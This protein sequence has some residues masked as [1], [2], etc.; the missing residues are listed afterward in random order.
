MN[1]VREA[2]FRFSQLLS[3]RH[4]QLVIWMIDVA[5][6]PAAFL[7]ACMFT[8][9]EI[10]PKTQLVRL[11]VMFPTLAL[12]GGFAS[13]AFGLPWI[14]LKTYESFGF[15]AIAPYA[16]TVGAV[17]LFMSMAPGLYFPVVGTLAFTLVLFLASMALRLGTLKLYFWSLRLRKPQIRV[18][19]YGAGTTGLQLASALKSHDTIQV[20]A[21]ID[22]DPGL[23]RERLAGLRI[24]PSHQ[25]DEIVR[26]HD[27]SRVI[28]A[29]PSLPA[30]QLAR[31]GRQLQALGLEVQTVP[32]F[33]QLLG[34]EELVDRLTPLSPGYFLGRDRLDNALPNGGEFYSGRVV[35][36]SGAGGSIGSEL[37]RQILQLRPRRLVMFEVSEP[38]LYAIDHELRELCEQELID[39]VPVLGS[40][41]DA[42]QVRMAL[43]DNGVEIVLHAAAYKHV[44]LVESNPLAGL[45]NNALGTRTLADACVRAGVERFILVSTDKAVRPTNVMGAS[46]R[47]AEL[48]VQDLARRSGDTH[49]AIVRFG[50]VLGSSGSVIPLFKEQI[51]RGGPI[52]L[53]HDDV[54]RFFMTINEAAR[55][56]LLAGSYHDDTARSR[57]DVYV[58]DMGKPVRIRNLA[59]Q[60]IHAA[61]YTVRDSQNPDG[62][63]EIKVVGLRPGEKLHEELLIGAGMARTPHPKIMRATEDATGEVSISA[64]LQDLARLAALGDSQGARD[65]AL[66]LAQGAP[67]QTVVLTGTAAAVS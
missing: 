2:L 13:L 30:P 12:A 36:V 66:G 32:S 28:V 26:N 19:V 31:L 38:T 49:F 39:L 34:T 52:T 7:L 24:H 46:K 40:V 53:T 63:I 57:A 29:M 3:R 23:Q 4:K 65:L 6:A 43:E 20:V 35:M 37:C 67:S 47:L 45:T 64:A 9:A 22:D 56:V 11:A 15:G 42:R 60:L 54:T 8:Y 21:F 27:I 25:I 58:L 62:D 41:T 14:K 1:R 51:A 59:E 10:W 61:G 18:L 33:G 16:V 48:V 50:N 17:A 5:V 44:P 55:L